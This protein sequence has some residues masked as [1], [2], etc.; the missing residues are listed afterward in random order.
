MTACRVTR[1]PLLYKT[2]KR[3][4]HYTIVDTSE[5]KET[6]GRGG[7]PAAEG[8][9]SAS[10]ELGVS[11]GVGDSRLPPLTEPPAH[12]TGSDGGELYHLETSL[13]A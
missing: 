13:E 6:P 2:S 3:D 8:G 1:D 7:S 12:H 4:L 11:V 9:A 10:G 5:D